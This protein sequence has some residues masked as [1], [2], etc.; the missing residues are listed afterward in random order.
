MLPK[1]FTEGMDTNHASSSAA[2]PP[3]VVADLNKIYESAVAQEGLQPSA[4]LLDRVRELHMASLTPGLI[5]RSFL[6]V[7]QAAAKSAAFNAAKMPPA[8]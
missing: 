6:A 4:A 2:L 5:M 3:E 1:D 7:R 8:K